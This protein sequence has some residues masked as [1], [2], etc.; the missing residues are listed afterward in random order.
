VNSKR[1]T[2]QRFWILLN[3]SG[4]RGHHNL[5]STNMTGLGSGRDMD[6]ALPQ[7]ISGF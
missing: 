5:Y 6:T 1:K 7:R 2:L 3:D 4:A